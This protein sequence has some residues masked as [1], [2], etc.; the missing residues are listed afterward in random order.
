MDKLKTELQQ[1]QTRLQHLIAQ[2]DLDDLRQQI[3]E[4]EAKSMKTGFWDQPQTAQQI[5]KQLSAI[6]DELQQLEKLQADLQDALILVDISTDDGD[7]SSELAELTKETNRLTR[8][9][10]Q[11]ETSLYLSG[12]Y[13]HSPALLTIHAGQGGVEAMDWVAMLLRMYLKYAERQGWQSQLIEEIPGEEAGFKTVTLL[14]EGRYPYGHLKHEAGT[15]R[16][17]RLSP[18]NADNLR[19]TSFAKVEVLP[20]LPETSD[21]DLVIKDDE[22]EFEAFRASGHGGQNVNKVSTAVRLKHVPTGITA[23]CQTQRTQEQNRKLAMEI[24]KSKLWNRQQQQRRE[25]EA[26]LKGDGPQHASWGTQIRNYVLHPYK[27]VKDL[28]TQVESSS[29]DNVLAGELEP[30][31]DAEIRMLSTTH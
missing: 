27:L 20:Q 25:T 2:R 12:P 26:N 7:H 16:L 13:D 31:I 18:F 5:M 4:L 28:R 11:L 23:T 24:L 8:I 3:R 17:V 9:L 29:P 14:I 30:F 21:L 10:D 15:H 22:I 19:Q 6:Q 1:L